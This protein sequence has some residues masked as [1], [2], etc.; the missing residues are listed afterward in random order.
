MTQNIPNDRE[1]RM[2]F[3]RNLA[4]LRNEKNNDYHG[5]DDY[6]FMMPDASVIVEETSEEHKE[7]ILKTNMKQD[8]SAQ[9]S[10]KKPLMQEPEDA[11]DHDTE[12]ACVDE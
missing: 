10:K 5:D 9:R 4:R 7:N 1:E 2:D 8:L 6:E 11:E 3:L 12:E